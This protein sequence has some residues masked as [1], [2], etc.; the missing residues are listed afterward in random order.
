MKGHHV[1]TIKAARLAAGFTQLQVALK[2][3]LA[4]STVSMIENGA[5]QPSPGELKRFAEL[6]GVAI[7]KLF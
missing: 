5:R 7:E 3:G 6:Y 4:R 1:S 2:L